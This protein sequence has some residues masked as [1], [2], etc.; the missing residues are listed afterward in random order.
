MDQPSGPDS[1]PDQEFRSSAPILFRSTANRAPVPRSVAIRG[2]PYAKACESPP[3]DCAPHVLPPQPTSPR[4]KVVR[5]GEAPLPSAP[6]SQPTSSAAKPPPPTLPTPRIGVF[7]HRKT[8]EAFLSRHTEFPEPPSCPPTEPLET[9]EFP[10]ASSVRHEDLADFRKS[11]L[12][13]MVSASERHTLMPF[14]PPPVAVVTDISSNLPDKLRAAKSASSNQIKKGPLDSLHITAPLP[15]SLSRESLKTSPP[16]QSQRPLPPTQ[17]TS[18]P[19]PEFRPLSK[20]ILASLSLPWLKPPTP[21]LAPVENSFSSEFPLRSPPA[22]FLPR[23]S[24]PP[25]RSP[26]YPIPLK[27]YVSPP[28]PPHPDSLPSRLPP[29]LTPPAWTATPHPPP[30]Q[31]PFLNPP[32]LD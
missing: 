24:A 3:T 2:S 21:A 11:D 6:T 7:L 14:P 22:N 19:P 30:Q 4:R 5:A 12:P 1:I 28:A 29:F 32:D 13:T 31:S 15:L 23:S 18:P 16:H 8:A 27:F 20:P 10:P 17:R 25:S 9:K 26:L